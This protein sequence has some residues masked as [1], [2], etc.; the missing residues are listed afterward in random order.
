[1]F[2]EKQKTAFSGWAALVSLIVALGLTVYWFVMQIIDLN[3]GNPASPLELVGNIV[4]FVGLLVTMHGFF[5]IEPNEAIVLL[6]FGR[7]IGTEKTTGFR[8]ANPFYTRKPISLRVRNFDSEKLKVND[9]RGNPI[10]ISAVV[11]WR[12]SDTAQAVFEVE[13]YTEYVRMQSESAL[14]HLATQYA[15]DSS[16]HEEVSLRVS[17]DEVSEALGKEIQERVKRAGVV[18]EEARI[19]HLAYAA[20]IASVMLQRQ[21]AEAIIAA[22]QKIVDGAVGMVQ[23]A[24]E[25]LST[26]GVLH[27]DEERKATMVSNLMVVLCAERAAQP[28][29]NTGSLY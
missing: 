13:N 5:T 22:R 1:M 6:L 7:Y 21:Q 26:E 11:V 2:K 18:I 17:I 19:N 20:E 16:E 10:D 15:Y 25:R 3:Q 23:M 24:L 28:V 14:R 9:K 8:W 29:L 4:L 12:V 27:L